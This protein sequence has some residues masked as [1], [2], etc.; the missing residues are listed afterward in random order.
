MPPLSARASNSGR[1]PGTLPR[2]TLLRVGVAGAG[3]RT[4]SNSLQSESQGEPSPILGIRQRAR[5]AMADRRGYPPKRL[6]IVRLIGF[7]L[8]VVT[9]SAPFFCRRT[10]AS[11]PNGAV[12]AKAAETCWDTQYQHGTLVKLEV[13]GRPAYVIKPAEPVDPQRRWVWIVPHWLGMSAPPTYLKVHHELYVESALAKGF[14]VAG[15]DIGV[16]CGSPA[17]VAVCQDFYSRIIKE[18][19]LHPKARMI[20]QSNGGLI[21]HGWAWRH[22]ECVDRI[23]EIYPALDMRSWP[24]LER[25]CGKDKLPEAGLGYDMTTEQLSKRLAEFNPI[26]NLKPLALAGV[27]IFITHGDK[28]T[29]VPIGPN[30]EEAVRRYRAFKGDIQMEVMPGRNHG[31][32]GGEPFKDRIFYNNRHGLEFLLQ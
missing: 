1:C 9:G 6:K 3:G 18:Y 31:E 14:H 16:S 24:T 20:A 7:L 10:W 17:G 25:V 11:E 21:A 27:K 29:L 2:R 5:R 22:P 8:I 30:S 13:K 12:K 26:D 23:F 19:E 28:D 32:N 4:Q 15:V